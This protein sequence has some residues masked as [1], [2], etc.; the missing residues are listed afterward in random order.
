MVS[1]KFSLIV[2]ALD[3]DSESVRKFPFFKVLF[4]TP[5]GVWDLIGVDDPDPDPETKFGEL[6]FKSDKTDDDCGVNEVDK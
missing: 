1:G 3:K 5:L 4:V 6:K 2:D